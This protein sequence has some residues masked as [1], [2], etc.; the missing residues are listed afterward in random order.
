LTRFDF[1]AGRIRRLNYAPYAWHSSNLTYQHDLEAL[2]AVW[3]YRKTQPLFPNMRWLHFVH[4]FNS[5]FDPHM[6][7]GGGLIALSTQWGDSDEPM[8]SLLPAVRRISPLLEELEL[9]PGERLVSED[10]PTL[11]ELVCGLD[12]L[13]TLSC[14]WRS[15]NARAILHIAS[16]PY[17]RA[18]QLPNAAED[19]IQSLSIPLPVLAFS[20]LQ[21][22]S[23]R[24]P[25]MP[26][27]CAL[28]SHIRPLHLKSITLDCE[29]LPSAWHTEQYFRTLEN[30]CSQ[31]NLNSIHLI[32][33]WKVEE[34]HISTDVVLDAAVLAPL[35]SFKNLTRL[36]IGLVYSFDLDNASIM[37]MANAWPKLQQLQL[38]SPLG[39]KRISGITLEGLVPLV[40]CCRDLEKLSITLNALNPPTVKASGIG[41]PNTK[42]TY[43][44]LGDSIIENSI[45]VANFLSVLFPNVTGIGGV[46]HY[47]AGGSFSDRERGHHKE[48]HHVSSHLERIRKQ[49]GSSRLNR[50][51]SES[52]RNGPS[53]FYASEIIP[54]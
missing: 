44:Q 7:L 49:K 8:T 5:W 23:M 51:D 41:C 29:S 11:S 20:S 28:L 32:H 17:L 37:D 16:L 35:R 33:S 45:A 21:H 18:L 40:I 42:I 54:A 24:V 22:L 12:R 6:F 25:S 34:K 13:R 3:N 30:C 38:G 36:E 43:L 53:A 15:L 10:S 27:C 14:G 19:I 47:V 1:Y 50:E 52:F 48:W 26:P 9:G 4:Q 46:W 2:R 39:W 31:T